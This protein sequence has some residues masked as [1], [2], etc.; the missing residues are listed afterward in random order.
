[1]KEGTT[2]MFRKGAKVECEERTVYGQEQLKV[3]RNVH[4]DC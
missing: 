2:Q 4:I 3:V 1:M